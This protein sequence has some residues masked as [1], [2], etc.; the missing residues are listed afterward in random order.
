MN[1]LTR[2]R[3]SIFLCVIVLIFGLTLSADQSEK[4]QQKPK[5]FD[6]IAKFCPSGWMGDLEKEPK[7]VEF[8]DGWK[9]EPHSTPVC[10]KITYT[11]GPTGWAGIYWHNK[12]NNWGEKPGNNFQKK[13]YKKITF[14]AKGEKGGEMVEFKAGGIDNT[15][16]KPKG[17]YKYKDSFEV[18]GGKFL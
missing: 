3:R 2:E 16:K 7:Y 14:W 13:R 17:K 18:T 12:P 15:S 11:F 9:K 5:P 10:V 6:V 8:F 4:K 1:R